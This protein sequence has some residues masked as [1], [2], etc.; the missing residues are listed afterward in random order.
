MRVSASFCEF[1]QDSPLV[2]NPFYRKKKTIIHPV[3]L[4]YLS[5]MTG[6]VIILRN[7]A[8]MSSFLYHS[9]IKREDSVFQRG[10]PLSHSK[11]YTVTKRQKIWHSRRKDMRNKCLTVKKTKT[12]Y[13]V[14]KNHAQKQQ[15]FFQF[16][17]RSKG[18][19]CMTETEFAYLR[20]IL[21]LH[22]VPNGIYSST[23]S[24]H[25][26]KRVP[27]AFDLS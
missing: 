22:K 3:L 17:Y 25:L 15:N 20:T 1:L 23:L 8:H 6:S 21:F 10:A 4:L 2:F 13:S 9:I 14:F 26:K 12:R 16:N 18:I 19:V 7:T 5:F 24:F 27:E 11:N